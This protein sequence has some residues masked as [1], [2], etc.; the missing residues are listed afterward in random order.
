LALLSAGT[1]AAAPVPEKAVTVPFELLRSGHMAVKVKVNG[2]GPFR[3]IFDTGA[4]ITLLN[5]KVAREADLLRGAQPP[6][7]ALFGAAGEV[8]V[9]RLEVGGVAAEDVPAIVMDHPTVE[10][11]GRVLGPVDGIVGFPFFA[12]YKMTL[13]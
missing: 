5:N 3:L 8:R 4:P 1:A 6:A 12:R 11:I 9:K 10:A 13:D 7:F 2:K